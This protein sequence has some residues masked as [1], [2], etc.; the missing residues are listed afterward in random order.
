MKASHLVLLLLMNLCWSGVYSAYKIIDQ[1]LSGVSTTAAIVTLRF[2]LAGLC[3]LVLWPLLPGRAPRGRDL[4]ITCLMGVTL[5]VVGQR[6]Q[7]YG[8]HIGTAGNSSVLMAVEPLVTSIAAAIFLRESIGPRRWAGFALGLL[9]VA[10]LN[11]V[12]SPGFQLAGLAASLI[13]LSSFI[14]EAA[15]SVLGKPVIMR[16]SVMKVLAISLLVGLGLNLLIDGKTTY[17]AAQQLTLTSWALITF[18]AVVCTVIGYTLWFIVIRECPINVAA[19]TIFAQSV[20]GIMLAALWVGEELHWGQLFGS[21][22]IVAGMVF[23]LSRQI[24]KPDGS[25]GTAPG[26]GKE[27]P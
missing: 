7:I 27:L 10:L 20:F 8:N 3:L 17:A 6:L 25:L 24:H 12:G 5:F 23:G 14:C 4:V 16:V 19:L 22:T 1:D 26:S 9:G 13:F 15:Y 11:G 2:G 21:L 18:L